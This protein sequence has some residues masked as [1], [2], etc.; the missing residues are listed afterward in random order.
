V[1]P[2]LP[3][4]RIKSGAWNSD[5]FVYTSGTLGS[6]QEVILSV[7][8]LFGAVRS[9]KHATVWVKARGDAVCVSCC[10][11][12]EYLPSNSL[13]LFAFVAKRPPATIYASFQGTWRQ[14]SSSRKA[15]RFFSGIDLAFNYRKANDSDE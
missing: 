11:S 12:D 2:A 15:A 9:A 7:P 5:G 6:G 13:E 10:R 4:S 3:G 1:C 8:R 14:I